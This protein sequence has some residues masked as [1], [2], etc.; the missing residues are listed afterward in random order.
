[1]PKLWHILPSLVLSLLVPS[2][3]FAG[4]PFENTGI[5]RTVE[6]GGTLVHVT[7][8]F[9]A[10]ALETGANVYTIALGLEQRLKTSWVEAK[11]KGQTTALALEDM[12]YD[13]KRWARPRV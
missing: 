6:L 3:A 10:K 7:T 5:I 4:Q 1:M 8:T 12:G 11:I 13:E 2:L 9:S